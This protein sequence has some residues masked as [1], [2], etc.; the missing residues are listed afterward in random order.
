[1][2]VTQAVIRGKAL[3]ALYARRSLEKVGPTLCLHRIECDRM[4]FF[5][6]QYEAWEYLGV[7]PR[8]GNFLTAQNNKKNEESIGRRFGVS[9]EVG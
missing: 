4:V 2:Y 3:L 9:F 5:S 8:T 1:M 7:A 6:F